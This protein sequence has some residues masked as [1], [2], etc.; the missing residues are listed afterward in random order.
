MYNENHSDEVSALAYHF[1]PN[2][3]YRIAVEFLQIPQP[4]ID[5]A[6]ISCRD[7]IEFAKKCFEIWINNYRG[8]NIRTDLYRCLTSV[9][10]EGLINRN[11]YQFLKSNC[12]HSPHPHEDDDDDD[13]H[14]L[15]QTSIYGS[16]NRED[17]SKFI[18]ERHRHTD[19]PLFTSES[20][21]NVPSANNVVQKTKSIR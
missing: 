12:H 4:A 1:P 8:N 20:T 9:S 18:P 15:E 7:N 16:Q 17:R 5:H 11:I 2:D 13:E 21:N 10:R 19:V 14:S 6:D 3:M